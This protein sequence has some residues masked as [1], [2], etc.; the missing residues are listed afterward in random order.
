VSRVTSVE[1]RLIEAIQQRLTLQ[2]IY[3]NDAGL[4]RLCQPHILYESTTGK[5]LVD[6]WQVSGYSS[7]VLPD[8]TPLEV[9]RIESVE[10]LQDSFGIAPG[11]NPTN[12][13]RYVRI[14]AQ[15]YD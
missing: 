13:Q 11:Y 15:V 3:D 2:L 12:R 8:W 9:A 4:E 14:I 6:T 5:T 10:L 1:A 7:R